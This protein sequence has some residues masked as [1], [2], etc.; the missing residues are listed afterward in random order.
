MQYQGHPPKPTLEQVVE[1]IF[2]TH[3]ITRGDQQLFMKTLLSKDELSPHEQQHIDR[4]FDGL[5]RG[6]IRVV[7]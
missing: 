7:D 1:R 6:L 3:R 4:V 2:T 5:R